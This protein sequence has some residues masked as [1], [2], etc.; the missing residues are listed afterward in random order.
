MKT[1][2]ERLLCIVERELGVDANTLTPES[3]LADLADSLDWVN[4][5]GAIEDEFR[6]QIGFEDGLRLQTLQDLMA[7]VTLVAEPQLVTA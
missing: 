7:L 3:H 4:L 6:L 5:I 1:P 2:M